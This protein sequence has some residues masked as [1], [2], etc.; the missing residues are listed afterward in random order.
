MLKRTENTVLNRFMGL[1]WWNPSPTR[2]GR[3]LRLFSLERRRLQR[4]LREAFQYLKRGCKNEDRPF[5]RVCC[6]RTRG[7]VFIQKEGWF[8]LDI[9][10]KL[11]TLR[12]VRHWHRLPREVVDAPSLETLSVRLDRALR[13]CWSRRCPCSLQGSWMGWPLRVLSNSNNYMILD[14]FSTENSKWRP[15]VIKLRTI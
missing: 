6:D 9:R 5:S 3:E 14:D 4:D 2:T 1:Y 15:S 13:T 10:K 12:V 8:K 11:F 7:N